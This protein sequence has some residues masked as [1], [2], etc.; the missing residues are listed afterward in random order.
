MSKQTHRWKGYV[1][2]AIGGIAGIL[3]M[4]Q[5]WKTVT[6]VVGHDPRRVEQED[7]EPQPLDDISLLG[8]NFKQGEST[9]AALGRI[10]Y[11]RLAGEEPNQQT[12]TALSY[13]IHWVISVDASGTYGMLRGPAT[14]PDPVGGT[15]LAVGLWLFGD[16][17]FMPLVGLA[18]GPTAYPAELHAHALGAHL[19]YGLA[20]AAA[21]Q[22]L[23]ILF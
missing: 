2:G 9:T 7:Q 12:K 14:F 15:A 19:A 5:Y 21:T 10:L 11:T 3:A 18:K 16:E 4:R 6:A 13:I 22:F 23:H 1:L 17:L 20:S 8:K